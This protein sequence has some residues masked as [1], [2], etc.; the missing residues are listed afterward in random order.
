MTRGPTR[1]ATLASYKRHRDEDT[2]RLT[3]DWDAN[4]THIRW[5]CSCGA[6]GRWNATGRPY[7]RTGV[8]RLWQHH[9]R[10]RH[11]GFTP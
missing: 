4:R 6:V 3:I 5:R 11:E 9:V 7:F 10:S 8:A 1:T 2:R